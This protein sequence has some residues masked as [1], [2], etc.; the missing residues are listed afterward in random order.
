MNFTSL[1][2]K[3]EQFADMKQ[4]VDPKGTAALFGGYPIHSALYS[5][6]LSLE[7]GRPV[8]YICETDAEAFTAVKDIESMCPQMK[9]VVFPS[10]SLTL[11]NVE[12]SS[13]EEELERLSAIGRIVSE[14]AGIVCCSIEAFLELTMPIGSFI[15]ISFS[16]KAGDRITIEEVSKRLIRAGYTRTDRVE[17]AGQFAVRGGIVD[18]F[19]GN[20]NDPV[21]VEFFGDQI[22]RISAFDPETQRRFE[23]RK[24]VTVIPAR[25]IVPDDSAS[26]KLA[27]L[28]EKAGEE[29]SRIFLRDSELIAQGI[30]PS[31]TDRYL[32]IFYDKPSTVDEYMVNPIVV[33]NGTEALK[34]RFKTIM[35]QQTENMSSLYSSGLYLSAMGQWY[36]D[37]WDIE[38]WKSKLICETFSH[39]L[40]GR[41]DAVVN[42]HAN[43][44][45][46]WD[47]QFEVLL[48]DLRGYIDLGYRCVL[49]AGTSRAVGAMIDDLSY[50]GITAVTGGDIPEPGTVAVCEGSLSSGFEISTSRL[51]VI[52][53]RRDRVNNKKKLTSVKSE[54]RITRLEDLHEGDYVV[55]KNHG[56]GIYSGIHRIDHHGFVRD[57]IKIQYRGADTLYVPVTQLDMVSQYVSPREDGEVKISRLNSGEWQ[58]TKQNVY[59]AV[60]EMASELIA[61]YAKREKAKGVAFSEDTDWQREFEARFEYDETADQL[62]T[63]EEIKRDMEKSRPMDRLLCGD[64]GVGKTEVAMRAVFKCVSDGYQCAVLVPTTI[65]AWQHFRTFSERMNAYPIKVAMLSRFA[66]RTEL[67]EAVKGIADGTVDIAIGTHKLLQKDINFKKLGLVVI[68]EEQRFGVAHKEKLKQAVEGVDVLTLSATPIPRTLNMAM[69]GI[70][71]MSVIEEPPEERH[72]IQTYVTEYDETLLF[73]AIKRELSRGGQVYYLHNRIENIERCAERLISAFPE[74]RI[75]VAHGRMD[76]AQLSGVWKRLMDGEIDIL[77]CTTIIETGVDVANVNTLI[78]ED[79]DR[80][81]LSQ[82][83]QIRGRVGRSSRRAFAYFTFRKDRILSEVASKRLSAIRDFTS[84]GSGF[85]IAMRDLQIRGA[86]SVLSARQS[87]HMAAVGYETYVDI[88]NKAIRDEAGEPPVEEPVECTVDL[89]VNAYI[90][91]SYIYDNESRIEMY[92]R[93]AAIENE[94]DA[95]GV[96]EELNDRFGTPPESVVNLITVSLVRRLASVLGIYDIK[97]NNRDMIYFYSDRIAQMGTPVIAG[98]KK[99]KLYLSLKGKSYLAAEVAPGENMCAVAGEVLGSY[100]NEK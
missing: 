1:I 72:P 20:E 74:A 24:S 5:S 14:D 80:M 97:S 29:L 69:S 87:G 33:L 86:G 78:V 9:P 79:A 32:N 41:L 99:R 56:I 25:E 3:S 37:E 43:T 96:S 92:K 63:S 93:I 27:K 61:L 52:T 26:E 47:G 48:E 53:G 16:L 8:L 11:I 45:P 19:S 70:R 82:L 12:S 46:R 94:E 88:L 42:I 91:E 10:R 98:N 59:R 85:R 58:K 34:N 81:G 55:H 95:S 77:V 22:D 51:C 35:W 13:H 40:G 67:K 90:P 83:Y 60:R 36:K 17:G 76:E 57:Y 73:D 71:D 49:M 23:N 68:D 31:T 65:L 66:S 4:A 89:A 50:E 39:T 28:S 21:R 54:N 64:V 15:N 30:I 18:I 38:K 44:M 75:E 84:F 6:A 62:K 7:T 2:T 100:K